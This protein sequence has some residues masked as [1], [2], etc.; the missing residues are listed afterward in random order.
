LINSSVIAEKTLIDIKTTYEEA[1]K[2]FE[3]ENYQKAIEKYQAILTEIEEN[4]EEYNSDEEI[5]YAVR[6]KLAVC[7]SK[8]GEQLDSPNMYRKSLE[9]IPKTYNQ[10]QNPKIKE[11]LMFLWGF[12]YYKLGKNQGAILKIKEFLDRYPNSDFAEN[13]RYTL[14]YIYYHN[15][16]YEIAR[17]EFN[18]LLKEFPNSSYTD[19]VKFLIAMSWFNEQKY[20]QAQTEFEKLKSFNKDLSGQAMYYNALSLLKLGEH[21]KAMELYITF[22]SYY[23][24][25]VYVP[26]AYF[27]MGLIDARMKRYY[28]AERNFGLALENTKDNIAKSEIQ[29]Q[30]GN[31]YFDNSAYK[32]AISAYFALIKSSPQNSHILDARFKIAESYWWQ[33]DYENALIEYKKILNDYLEN[34]Y[35]SNCENR[36]SEIESI[37]NASQL[38][39]TSEMNNIATRHNT[40]I[41]NQSATNRG[42]YRQKHQQELLINNW[43]TGIGTWLS[44]GEEPVG[45]SVRSWSALDGQ[46]LRVAALGVF[47]DLTDFNYSGSVFGLLLRY[48]FIRRYDLKSN[49]SSYGDGITIGNSRIKDIFYPCGSLGLIGGIINGEQYS[50]SVTAWIYGIEGTLGFAVDLFPFE[51]SMDLLGIGY[52]GISVEDIG[53]AGGFFRVRPS[54]GLHYYF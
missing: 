46:E 50:E 27:D 49:Q 6:Y 11:A 7:Y 43:T 24:N 1:E 4:K 31:T 48:R 20:E 26:A 3:K 44:S 37:Q 47:S 16:K 53:D 35:K 13:S 21:K 34:K 18:I 42:V 15:K 2:D 30:I 32:Q 14:A 9:Y 25:H 36:I 39:A 10:T 23:P 40:S 17:D 5:N 45:L 12:N 51:I 29:F 52:V 8:L 28:E 22:T 41:V 54:I 38:Y 19:D 33:E